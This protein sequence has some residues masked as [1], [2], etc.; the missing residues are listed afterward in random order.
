M[1]AK[2][3]SART[4]REFLGMTAAGSA[5]FALAPALARGQAKK[6]LNVLWVTCEDTSPDLGCYGDAYAVTPNLDKLA[7]QGARYTLAFTHAPVCAPSRSGIITG[8]YP[9][10]I[11]SHHMRCHAVPQPFV[12]CFPEYLRAAGYYCTNNSKTDYNFPPPLTAWDECS[13]D[14]HWRNRPDKAQPFFAVFNFTT[15]HESQCWPNDGPF[16]HDPAKAVL[17]PYYADTP[18]IRRNW[19]R[20]YDQVTRM[21]GQ[22]AGIL[23][24]LEEDGLADNT[25]VFFYGDHG[26]GLTR[27]K[28]WV[29]D[30]GIRV[31]L[32][33]RWPGQIR[34][35]TVTD[36]LVAFIDFGPTV[37]SIAGIKPPEHMQG[38]AFLGDFDTPPREYVFAHR[39]R[40]DETY[41]IIRAVRDKRFK[42]I[43]NFEPQKPYAQTIKYM[44]K[45]P[46]LQEMRRLHAEGKLQG[47]PALWF[48]DHKPAEELYDT[49]ADPHE[50]VNLAGNPEHQETLKRFRKVLEDWMK[51][52]RDLGLIPEKELV[53]RGIPGGKPGTASEP[54]IDPAGGKFRP[55]VT[56]TITCPTDGASIAWTTDEGKKPHWLLYSKPIPLAKGATL[57]ARACRLG[58]KDSPEAR[59]SFQIA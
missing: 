50:V 33:I 51:E 2:H 17:P 19:A 46:I 16:Q 3:T 48:A 6:P 49:V 26:R 12:R 38:R 35:G 54:K 7:A 22:V 40:M 15:T 34:P 44:E 25:V 23:K 10:T 45:M 28:R 31:P 59:A 14:A 18:V 55:P 37:L 41:D 43:R 58:W 1:R 4:R 20:Y 27:G 5:A 9:T 32:L 57:R 8:M 56:V 11:G 29:Y 39:D 36:R 52:T 30:S 47:P 24:Q 42:Y 53:E 21:D 13:R